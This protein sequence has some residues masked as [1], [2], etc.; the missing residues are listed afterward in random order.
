MKI[1][2][3]SGPDYLPAY[4]VKELA[5]E[6]NIAVLTVIFRQCLQDG[7]LPQD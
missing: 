5:D 7:L 2:K 3:D 1:N 6:R 4:M